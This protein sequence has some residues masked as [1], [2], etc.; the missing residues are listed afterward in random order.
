MKIIVSQS[1]K[2][3]GIVHPVIAIIRGISNKG[4]TSS[5]ILALAEK[6]LK[7]SYEGWQERGTEK[8][9]SGFRELFAAMGYENLVPAGERLVQ[10]FGA[11]GFKSYGPLIDAYNTIALR[12]CAGIGMHDAAT[13]Q[14]DIYIDRA[15]GDEIIMPLFKSDSVK[16]KVGDLHYRD[17]VG[18]IAWLGKRDVD[19]DDRKVTESTQSVMMVVLGNK[20]TTSAHNIKIARDF[21]EL[22]LLASPDAELEV[23]LPE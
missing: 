18:V 9:V 15:T 3:L 11:K 23:M 4:A 6:E 20:H 14:G 19:S 10:S 22:L 8:E 21:F 2:A 17:D 13:V 16:L 7:S 1:A 5:A 12:Y